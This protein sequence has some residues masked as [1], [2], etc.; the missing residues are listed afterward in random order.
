VAWA[1]EKNLK[2]PR[3]TECEKVYVACA[4]ETNLK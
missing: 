3:T 4:Q 2:R 1:Q